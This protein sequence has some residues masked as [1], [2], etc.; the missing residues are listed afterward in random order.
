M[1]T[2]Y[3]TFGIF[4]EAEDRGEADR[5]FTVFTKKF[6]K[7]KI[8]GRS[9]R[10]IKSKLRAGSQ[11]F[12]LSYIEFI[13]GK[14]YKTLIEA[15]PIER[16]SF[17]RKSPHKFKITA[18]IAENVC[19]FLRG[20]EPDQKIWSLLLEVLSLLNKT[21][22]SSFCLLIYYYFL[23]NFYSYLG[24]KIS[25]KHCAVCER[26]SSSGDLCF[27]PEQ[28]GT[29]CSSCSKKFK[30]AS[31]VDWKT[32]NFINLLLEKKLAHFSNFE[33][34]PDLRKSTK[35]ITQIYLRYLKGLY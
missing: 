6:G 22:K 16:F 2:Q 20:E 13:Q 14:T 29:I 4:L 21:K 23:W 7:L 32:V 3:K 1:F 15:I 11:L 9:I 10:K 26:K 30:S 31:K 12:S 28:G 27:D 5:F 25:L 35:K 8:L 33:M 19:F 34:T 24:Y 18:D 17:L